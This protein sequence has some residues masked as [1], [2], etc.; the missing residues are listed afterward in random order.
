MLGRLLSHLSYANVV[1]T[2]CLFVVLGGTAYAATSLPVNSVGE[3]QLKANAV[4]SVK[5][6]DGSLLRKDFRAGQLLTGQ[7]GPAG[8]V[9]ATGA[10]GAQGPA[11]PVGQQGSVGQA[12]AAGPP[13]LQGPVGATGAPGAQGPAGPQGIQGLTGANGPQG[14]A[15][16]FDVGKISYVTSPTGTA[17]STTTGLMAFIDAACPAGSKVLS[18][19][20]EILSAADVHVVTSKADNAG[21]GWVVFVTNNSMSQVDFRATAVC[22]AP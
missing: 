18:G 5:V 12:G 9:G 7:R 15:G 2:I 20:F 3:A 6:Q 16:G 17:V 4:S 21:T 1:S 14:P 11:G 8:P 22:A 10:P 19:G 13:G